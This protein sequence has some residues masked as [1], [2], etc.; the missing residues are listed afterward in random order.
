MLSFTTLLPCPLLRGVLYCTHN[1]ARSWAPTLLCTPLDDAPHPQWEWLGFFSLPVRPRLCGGP[2]LLARCMGG[3]N[4]Y[5]SSTAQ[6]LSI[7]IGICS[8]ARYRKREKERDTETETEEGKNK[9]TRNTTLHDRHGRSHVHPSREAEKFTKPEALRCMAKRPDDSA[10]A[11]S[12]AVLP[13]DRCSHRIRRNHGR[14]SRSAGQISS[15]HSSNGARREAY[16]PLAR[17]L[18]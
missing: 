9:E 18:P 16:S 14:P 11:S 4:R 15:Q 7:E 6:D 5:L 17:P 13:E 1:D 8:H 12:R 3:L 2:G 10:Y